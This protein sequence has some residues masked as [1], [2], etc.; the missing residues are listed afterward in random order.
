MAY[1]NDND[2]YV[3]RWLRNLIAAGHLP[4]GE[5][6]DRSITQLDPA[7]L[8]DECHFFA[9]IGGWPLA[10]QW[11]GWTGPVWTGSCPCQPFS[12]AGKR[13][14]EAD[15]RHLWP[16]FLALI[17]ECRPSTVFGEQVAGSSGY[18]WLDGVRADLEREGYRV[19]AADLPA[20]CVGSPHR[21][22]RLFWVADAE[23]TNR[24]SIHGT[25][26]VGR[27]R[28]AIPQVGRCR[29]PGWARF[30][31]VACAD[32]RTRRIEPGLEPMAKRIP[33]RVGRLRGYGNSICPQVAAE[34]VSAYMEAR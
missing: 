26:A 10:L 11:A 18:R 9:G 23:D 32:K 3:C 27:G 5:V 34:F 16:A 17:S 30:E 25:E 24:R 7:T 31:S 29:G 20:A 33:D 8:G 22:Q 1:Y 28:G 13:K 2:P 15:E 4:P 19:G 12:A 14:G 6:D 21:R